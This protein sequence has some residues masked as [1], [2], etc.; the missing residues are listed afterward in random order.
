MNS[1]F[2]FF[3]IL[4]LLILSNSIGQTNYYVKPTGIDSPTQGLSLATPFKTINYG[5]GQLGPGDTLNIM[6]GEYANSTFGDYTF[7][8]PQTDCAIYMN[9]KNGTATAN[10]VVRR[11]KNDHVVIKGDGLAVVH[12]KNSTYIKIQN[13]EVFGEVNNIPLDTALQYQ[14]L[15]KDENGILKYRMPPLSP[16]AVVEQAV[17]PVLHPN[18]DRPTYFNTMGIIVVSS[19]HIDVVD[20]YVHH[21]PGEGIR[22]ASSDFIKFLRNEVH[23]CS[24]RS[25]SGV[26]GM[27]IYTMVSGGNVDTV[28]IQMNEN[29]I[30]HNYNEVYSWSSTKTFITP[31][32]DE[33]KGITVQRCTGSRDWDFGKIQIQNNVCYRNGFAGIQVNEGE[34]VDIFNNSLYKNHYTHELT[35]DGSQLG[36]SAQTAKNIKMNNNI[37]VTDPQYTTG[38][39]LYLLNSTS[40]IQIDKNIV[41]GYLTASAQTTATNTI[42]ADP[43]YVN[44]DQFIYRLKS[45]SIAIDNS[46]PGA[47]T[48]DFYGKQRI[49]KADIGAIEILQGCAPLV[50]IATNN[51]IG[52]LRQILGC[53]LEGDTIKF[54]SNISPIY[55]SEPLYIDKYITVS[56]NSS[57]NLTTITQNLSLVN[58][59]QL[60]ILPGKI[61]NISNMHFTNYNNVYEVPNINVYGIM[62][63][64]D[65]NRITRN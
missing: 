42:F 38:R 28:T 35:G 34:R 50:T 57:I 49:Q 65:I 56:G 36:I 13:L 4:T 10:I 5:V 24:R 41:V 6:E 8:K 31:H 3:S 17:L 27:S 59:A 21:M 15:Y 63:A 45:T 62:N 30:H 52:S 1:R 61:L 43:Q 54:S 19:Q 37:V 14:F 47:P 51:G 60:V 25:A 44:P 39:A 32:F 22:S 64:S 26:H 40:N 9:G 58:K 16:P 23:D 7:F 18:I 20:N 46:G 33:G 11:Y 53:V 2:I 12:I 48:K 29:R 55:L